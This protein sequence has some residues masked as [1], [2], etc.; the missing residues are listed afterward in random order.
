MQKAVD[1]FLGLLRE[2]GRSQHTL[3]A[4]G[5]DLRR[6]SAFAKKMY[7]SVMGWHDITDAHLAAYMTEL[8]KQG[9]S[10]ATIVRKSVVLDRF[11]GFS[12]S[13]LRVTRKQ[14][15]RT[16]FR[17]TDNSSGNGRVNGRVNSKVNSKVNGKVNEQLGILEPAEIAAFLAEAAQA[18]TPAARRDRAL[19][20]LLCDVGARASELTG[21]NVGDFDQ[22]RQTIVLKAG[23][24]GQRT[25]TLQP[26]TVDAL[27]DY[28][29][30][31]PHALDATPPAAPLF[32]NL[33]GGRLTRQAVWLIVRQYATL[34]PIDKPV[35]PRTI[36]QSLLTQPLSKNESSLTL[37][38]VRVVTD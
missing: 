1:E 19:L 26:R 31:H 35:T 15:V 11:F 22:N 34:L 8:E 12:G 30:C 25:V 32:R 28:L 18:K 4:Y 24:P 21:V 7:P 33:R 10:P 27:T 13:S 2:G 9:L 23:G 20:E 29:A 14:T 5:A 6:F 38:G 17:D 36:R 3:S 37:D 16:R